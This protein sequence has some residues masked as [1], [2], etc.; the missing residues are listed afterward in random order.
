[1]F[2]TFQEILCKNCGGGV[3]AFLRKILR[4]YT[5]HKGGI[6]I[7]FTFSIPICIFLL[8]FVADHYRF[9][10]LKSKVKTSTY[11]VSSMIQ[12]LQIIGQENG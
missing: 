5:S 4:L 2:K 1:M 9:Y 10:E 7:E 11:L 6:L 12:Q 8:F 3:F